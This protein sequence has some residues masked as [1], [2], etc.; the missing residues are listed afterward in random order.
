MNGY[1]FMFCQTGN[2]R[3]DIRVC[4]EKQGFF[5]AK[6]EN[7]VTFNEHSQADFPDFLLSLVKGGLVGL[8][9]AACPAGWFHDDS[10]TWTGG[11][12]IS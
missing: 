1:S 10:G 11:R 7:G 2:K 8:P 3:D 5:A 12:M 4:I 9:D 6:P